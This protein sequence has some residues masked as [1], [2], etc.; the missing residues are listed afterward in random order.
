MP[1]SIHVADPKAFWAP[2]DEKNE[3]WTELKDH[4]NWW[5]G[6]RTKFPPR[7][8]LLKALEK[9]V[10]RH[11]ETTFVCVHFAN[12]A[13]DLAWVDAQLDKHPNMMADIAA[14][15]PEIGRHDP[16]KVHDIF[17]KHQD[18]LLFATDFQVGERLILGSGGSGPSP[19]EGD[20]VEFFEKHWRWLE[21]WDKDFVHMT[22][23]QGNW[24]ISGIGLPDEVLEK[25]Y[26]GNARKLLARSFK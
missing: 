23:I 12:N 14:R 11:P 13:E 1:V 26:F 19:T 6:D 17:V 18:R 8:D 20:A 5:F 2:Y 24:K 3:R 15:V 9:V 22:P 10:A 7:E 25:I 21:T 4:K 16:K